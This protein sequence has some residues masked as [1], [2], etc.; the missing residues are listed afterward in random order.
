MLAHYGQGNDAQDF[1]AGDKVRVTVRDTP[2]SGATYEYLD[3]V[4]SVGATT[5]VLTTGL[6]GALST[7]IDSVVMLQPWS[8]QTTDR[9]TGDH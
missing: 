4:A 7:S 1:V 8:E 9:K 6:A 5:I 3:T 2:D